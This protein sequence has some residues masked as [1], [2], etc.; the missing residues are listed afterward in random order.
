MLVSVESTQDAIKFSRARVYGTN[1]STIQI[2][3][4]ETVNVI[5]MISLF[6]FATFLLSAPARR[7]A[8][9]FVLR[10][11]RCSEQLVRYIKNNSLV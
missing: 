6:L 10:V 9:I 2:C 11:K 8:Q 3:V 4:I 5:C 7:E 1:E